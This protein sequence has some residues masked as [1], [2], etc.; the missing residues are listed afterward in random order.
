MVDGSN[1]HQSLDTSVFTKKHRYCAGSLRDTANDNLSK[2]MVASQLFWLLS[3]GN[4]RY[5]THVGR[6]AVIAADGHAR[7]SH[8]LM[9]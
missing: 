2:L 4:L 8:H 7:L 1:N 5:F 9:K 6:V 3:P